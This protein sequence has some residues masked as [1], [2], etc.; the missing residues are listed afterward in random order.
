MTNRRTPRDRGHAAFARSA[1]VFLAA[2]STFT[3]LAAAPAPTSASGGGK[4]GGKPTR[5]EQPRTETR[6]TV[7]GL[8][9]FTTADLLLPAGNPD[10]FEFTIVLDGQPRT[11]SAV[12]RSLRSAS[13]QVLAQNE[14]GELVSVEPPPV[15][16]YRGLVDGIETQ[17]AAFS[18]KDGA[19]SGFFDLG[20]DNMIFVQPASDFAPGQPASRHIVYRNAAVLPQDVRCG[21]G[22]YGLADPDWKVQGLPGPVGAGGGQFNDAGS[23]G[24]DGSGGIAGAQPQ[25]VEIGFDADF[26]FFQKNGNSII[27]T[28]NDIENVMNGVD[29]IYDRDV[30]IGYEFTTFVVRNTSSDPY[31]TTNMG[32]LLCEFRTTWNSAPE[33]GIQREIAQLYTGKT[34]AGNTIGL[35]WLGVMCNEIGNDCGG[36]GNLGYSTVESRY[37][38]VLANRQ[39]L[40]AHELGHNWN[41]VHCDAEAVC[42]IM[43][44]AAGG[45][46]GI[47]GANL[48]FGP[49]EQADINAFKAAV[50]CDNTE[51]LPQPIPFVDTIP[52]ATID[53]TKWTYNNGVVATTAATNEPSP[54]RS[55]VLDASGPNLYD[56]DEIRSNRILLG[57]LTTAQA[58]YW[59]QHKGVEAG[60]KLFVEYWSSGGDWI[61]LNTITSDGVDEL[62]FTQW[63]HNLPA[64]ARHDGFRIRFRTDS[65]DGTDDWY[66]DDVRVDDILVAP[67]ANDEC[68][69]A[70]IIGPGA[71][72]FDTTGATESFPP[73]PSSCNEGAGTSLVN[74]VWYIVQ[75]PCTGTLTVSTCGTAGFDTKLV[76]YALTGCPTQITVPL[77]CSDNGPGCANGTS[78]MSFQV[79]Q[80]TPYYIRL[81]GASG[82]GTGT[83]TITCVQPPPP[84]CPADRNADGKVDGADLAVILGAWGTNG[85]DL[86]GDNLTDGADLA[87]LLGAWGNCP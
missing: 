75:A 87:V 84:P 32:D 57:G 78:S 63:L 48:K 22:L 6:L 82:G 26:E 59:T 4:T 1:A 72:A 53:G 43:C 60:K 69:T 36:F 52:N 37:S 68:L 49:S 58:S 25:I 33:S 30:N 55:L 41:A 79:V 62:N 71:T 44:A 67:P 18:L 23:G 3:L 56:F 14:R 15:R 12:R 8:A 86:T 39:A 9:E 28:V 42:H 17:R 81:G 16:T 29:F 45:C 70:S 2:A 5:A 38:L 73:L 83:L 19:I 74:D 77:A 50:T 10:A 20:D 61:I 66:V 76:A 80:N 85:A 40:S 64:N 11:V 35:A 21:V 7:D 31:T 34:I 46:D 24:D 51:P 65:V 13:F 47:A 27:N 54:T